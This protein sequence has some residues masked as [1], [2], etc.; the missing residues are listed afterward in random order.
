MPAPAT[1]QL[2]L[3]TPAPLGLPQCLRDSQAC[4]LVAR[5]AEFAA[6]QQEYG[7]FGSLVR[8]HAWTPPFGSPVAPT[9]RHQ[10][11][12]LSAD[13]RRDR[14]HPV[15]EPPLCGC[16]DVDDLLYRGACVGCDWEGRPF[17]GLGAHNKAIEDACDHAWPGWRDLPVVPKPPEPGTSA[18]AKRALAA[19]AEKV[20]AACPPGWLEAG[21]P[22]RTLRTPPGTRHAEHGSRFG[23]YDLAVIAETAA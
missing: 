12:E 10:A 11:A 20:A 15:A 2:D 19:W 6:W 17:A 9:R 22:I 3:F 5:T 13:L 14:H 1:V 4:G 16:W 7:S 21:G 23:G 8:S 18:A